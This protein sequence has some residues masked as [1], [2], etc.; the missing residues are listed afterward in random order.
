MLTEKLSSIGAMLCLLKAR[1]LKSG[2]RKT[3][4]QLNVI[5]T[6]QQTGGYQN[7]LQP[8]IPL[9]LMVTVAVFLCIVANMLIDIFQL[10]SNLIERFLDRR[11]D[12]LLTFAIQKVRSI[13]IR[14]EYTDNFQTLWKRREVNGVSHP[15]KTI[16]AFQR[17]FTNVS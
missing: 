17:I 12:I 8:F 15:K 10:N 11:R 3:K 6:G 2:K 13:L 9:P 4:K 5:P 14:V 1:Q 7:H 16:V